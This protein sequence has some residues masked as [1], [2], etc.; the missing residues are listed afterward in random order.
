MTGEVEPGEMEGVACITLI[1][2]GAQRIWQK[3]KGPVYSGKGGYRKFPA[4]L[5]VLV[6]GG[7]VEG[8][9]TVSPLTVGGEMEGWWESSTRTARWQGQT[10]ATG[11]VPNLGPNQVPPLGVGEE[12]CL[13]GMVDLGQGWGDRRA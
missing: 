6:L 5:G 8:V 3:V 1:L 12:E 13:A 11:R 9:L 2:G 7:F 4:N 10:E